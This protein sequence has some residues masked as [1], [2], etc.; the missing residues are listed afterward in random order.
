MSMTTSRERNVPPDDN[1]IELGRSRH[2]DVAP[3]SESPQAHL[4]NSDVASV[5]K[6]FMRNAS[7]AT[8]NSGAIAAVLSYCIASISMTV[9]NK[10]TVSGEKFTMNL[11]VLLLSLIHI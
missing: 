6:N 10:F 11:L 4:L 8:A 3:E 7:H 5:T 1:E 9:I 2:S